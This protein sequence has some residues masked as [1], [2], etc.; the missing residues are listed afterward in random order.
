MLKSAQRPTFLVTPSFTCSFA[1]NYYLNFPRPALIWPCSSA[2]R[3]T[4]ICSGGRG[5]RSRRSQ[6]FFS[7]SVRAHF[8][9]RAIA[10]KETFEI[11]IL[12]HFSMLYLRQLYETEG[13]LRLWCDVG[14][15][16]YFP[17]LLLRADFISVTREV[18]L[19][20]FLTFP[21]YIGYSEYLVLIFLNLGIKDYFWWILVSY[22]ATTCFGD[23]KQIIVLSFQAH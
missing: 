1:A 10:Q 7:F 23:I 4:V 21:L 16:I 6:R 8:L 13:Y 9:S 22:W 5:F 2:G 15:M 12:Q 19:K 18:L 17:K 3:A 11:F 20:R 14:C